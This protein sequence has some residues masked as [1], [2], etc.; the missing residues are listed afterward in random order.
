MTK[1]GHFLPYRVLIRNSV[2]VVVIPKS[3]RK[4]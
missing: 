2:S 3:E 4:G 1:I